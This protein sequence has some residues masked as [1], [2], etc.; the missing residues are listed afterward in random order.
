M[1]VEL[2]L[3]SWRFKCWRWRI[4]SSTRSRRRG[5]IP[6]RVCWCIPVLL[7]AVVLGCDQNEQIQAVPRTNQAPGM[8]S[9]LAPE[10][11]PK[12][13]RIL[14]ENAP[15]LAVAPFTAA[16]ARRHQAAWAKPLGVEPEIENSVGMKLVLIPPG[17]FLMGS[18]DSEDAALDN[19]R[20]Q[21][22]VRITK[23]FYL[24]ATEVTQ[25]QWDAVMRPRQQRNDR[26]RARS[27]D[28]EPAVYVS[29]NDAL[30]FCKRL[31][32]REK[33]VYRLP[34]EAEWE[35]AC[36][37]GTTTRYHFGDDASQLGDYAWFAANTNDLGETYAHRTGQKQPNAFGLYDMHGNLW[38]WCADWYD[39]QYYA[40]APTDDPQG[41]SFGAATR[42]LR[43][44]SWSAAAENCRSAYRNSLSP[45][46]RY[47]SV[48][49][50]V[51]ADL[52]GW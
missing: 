52:S 23:S 42:V 22:R 5:A 51:A 38:E 9:P 34:T 15:E 48:G 47:N 17:E 28:D 8:E 27:A 24:A 19:E 14:E 43:G 7:G 11:G 4:N 16:V 40:M 49:F 1:I 6:H 2:H 3:V 25:A 29:W 46:S 21:H 30:E 18:P 20:P 35:F 31:S 50:R 39:E 44:G 10:P 13:A 45:R 37:A 33:R 41:P 26:R 36:R 12:T 32:H